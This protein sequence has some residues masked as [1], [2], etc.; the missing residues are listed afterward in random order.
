MTS[1]NHQILLAKRPDGPVDADCFVAAESAVPEPGD[2]EVLVRVDYLSIDPTIRMWMAMDTYLPAIEIG[3]PIR[4][5]GL[6]TVIESN[7]DDIP[8]GTVLFGTPGWQE[9]AVMGPRDQVV[10]EGVDPTA[11]LSVFGITGLTAYFG[12][13][14]IGRP[15]EGETVVISGAAGATGSV[16]GQIAKLQGCRVVGIAGSEEKCRWL[17]EE[18]G[19]DAAINYRT[20]NVGTAL[21][22]ACPNG[23]DVFFDNVGGEILEAALANLAL[24][25]RVVMCGAI[26]QYNDTV[27]PAG[28]RNLSVLI[29]KRGRIEG[30]IILDF[31]PRA[32][33]AIAQL[34]TWVMSGQ[35][36]YK[37]DVLDGLA[38]A[39]EALRRLF[40]GENT[41][42]MLV[43]LT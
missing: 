26:S 24:H 22:A 21:H 15:K 36:H 19:F 10:P 6:G 27:P 40:S 4:S 25:G 2:G 42:K 37:V 20:E 12:L 34:A 18:L 43:H 38:A 41:G 17:T 13:M 14:E 1:I 35:I 28:P 33:E 9:Y 11:A 3:A 16:A 5:A 30:F 32:G 23:I 29:S 7:N 39:P 8:V 31:L